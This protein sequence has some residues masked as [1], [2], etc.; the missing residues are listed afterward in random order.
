MESVNISLETVKEAKGEKLKKQKSR[1]HSFLKLLDYISVYNR[2]KSYQRLENKNPELVVLKDKKVEKKKELDVKSQH[3]P[4]DGYFDVFSQTVGDVGLK[5]GSPVENGKEYNPAVY[6]EDLNQKPR[7]N[8]ELEDP[9]QSTMPR[10][11]VFV[12]SQTLLRKLDQPQPTDGR[13]KTKDSE[14]SDKNG[15][16]AIT[17]TKEE[18]QLKNRI[19][20]DKPQKDG[21]DIKPLQF[22]VLGAHKES[23]TVSFEQFLFR[24]D[25]ELDSSFKLH[26]TTPDNVPQPISV[27]SS[28]FQERSQGDLDLKQQSLAGYEKTEMEN[29]NLSSRFNLNFTF[30]DTKLNLQATTNSLLLYIN[31]EQSLN[32]EVLEQIHKILTETGYANHNIVVRDKSK[33]TKS[34]SNKTSFEDRKIDGFSISA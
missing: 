29:Q 13:L 10:E 33:I 6:K 27:V 20:D 30:L 8:L 31:T 21:L 7:V 1:G 17:I 11:E 9:H 19:I 2:E 18:K 24:V 15:H 25:R 16:R 34:Y 28:S 4:I 26:K 14:H 5:S 22:E 23:Q 12:K 32:P 3:K